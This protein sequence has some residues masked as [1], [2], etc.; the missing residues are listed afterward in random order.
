M[1][2]DFIMGQIKWQKKKVDEKIVEDRLREVVKNVRSTREEKHI[3]KNV[4]LGYTAN[5]FI[6]RLPTQLTTL[7]KLDP[8]KTTEY[9]MKVKWSSSDLTEDGSIKGEF[10]I[11]RS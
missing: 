2:L 9:K 8:K 7:L 1:I 10:K 11:E 5:Q 3:E 4:S 6:I